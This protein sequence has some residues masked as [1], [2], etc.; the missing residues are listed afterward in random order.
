MNFGVFALIMTYIEIKMISDI[1]SKH[2]LLGKPTHMLT[3]E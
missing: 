1:P 2:T 3:V